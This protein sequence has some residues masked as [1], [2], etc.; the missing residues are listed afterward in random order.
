[1][2]CM[3]LER[4]QKGKMLHPYFIFPK[5]EKNTFQLIVLDWSVLILCYEK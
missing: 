5:T 2:V 3:V 1:M 4:R